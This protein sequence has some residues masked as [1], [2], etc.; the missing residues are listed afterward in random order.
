MNSPKKPSE[1]F[2]TS[3]QVA[4]NLTKKQ[5]CVL[6]INKA[7]RIGWNEPMDACTH[8]NCWN[9]VRYLDKAEYVNT[10]DPAYLLDH[11]YIQV[12]LAEYLECEENMPFCVEQKKK[13]MEYMRQHKRAVDQIKLALALKKREENKVLSS[14][15]V[16]RFPSFSFSSGPHIVDFNSSYRNPYTGVSEPLTVNRHSLAEEWEYLGEE[17]YSKEGEE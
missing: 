12:T 17:F 15:N 9:I 5:I 2:L 16:Q 10:E 7:K 11:Y 13:E 4:N 3:E 6:L 1:I 8:Q 14:K